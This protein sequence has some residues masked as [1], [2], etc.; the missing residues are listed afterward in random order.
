MLP[1]PKKVD[2]TTLFGTSQ[3]QTDS[4]EEEP[5]KQ[6]VNDI[7][8]YYEDV[9]NGPVLLLIHG[10]PLDHTLWTYQL[11][12]LRNEY[13]LVAPDL[14]GHGKSQA[15]PGPYRMEQMAKDLRDLI[16]A[17]KIERVVL[18]GLSMGGYIIHDHRAHAD[19]GRSRRRHH[20]TRRS[21]GDARDHSVC[22]R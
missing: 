22:T 21:R 19:C 18:M 14:R 16:D 20:P 5:V 6:L 2:P 9:G 13:R 1:L 10:F 11:E 4:Q 3:D 15:P 8:M 17:L 7:Q 12:S